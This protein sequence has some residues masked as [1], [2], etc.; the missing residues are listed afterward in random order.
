[1][2]AGTEIDGLA[3]ATQ[4]LGGAVLGPR[5]LGVALGF[6][7]LAVLSAPERTAVARVGRP[8]VI[9]VSQLAG[10]RLERMSGQG[11]PANAVCS[12]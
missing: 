7:P 5:E 8:V 2:T 11:R 1:M 12:R 6:D 10:H 4:A 3:T 9:D